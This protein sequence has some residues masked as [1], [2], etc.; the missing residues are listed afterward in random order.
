[1]VF[2]WGYSKGAKYSNRSAGIM[3]IISNSLL[4]KNHHC[5][6][7]S[8]PKDLQGR[9]GMVRLKSPSYDLLIIYVYCAPSPS[10]RI[11]FETNV[12]ISQWLREQVPRHSRCL[13]LRIFS[14]DANARVGHDK[15]G[16]TFAPHIGCAQSHIEDTNGTILRELVIDL[17]IAL[18]NIHFHNSPIFFLNFGLPTR[19]DYVGLSVS[20]LSR[21]QSC[22][23]WQH[24]GDRLQPILTNSR[25]CLCWT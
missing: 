8:P 3:I 4:S 7:I 16:M 14:A 13:A 15:E 9:V 21:V 20:A 6:T 5:A 12:R 1:M 23:T 18:V 19:I 2:S 11:R 17:V 22:Q 24:S 25:T 10:K